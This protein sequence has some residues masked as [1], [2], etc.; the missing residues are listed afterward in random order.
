MI[1]LAPFLEWGRM[2]RDWTPTTC[3]LYAD[4]VRAAARWV[5]EHRGVSLTGAGAGDVADW[6]AQLSPHPGTRNQY[7]CALVAYYEWRIAAGLHDGPNPAETLPSHRQRRRVPIAVT[8]DVAGRVLAAADELDPQW[9]SMITVALHTGL[10]ATELRTLPWSAVTPGFVRVLGKGSHERVVPLHPRA[11]AA[12]ER[13]RPSAPTS[14]WVW[15]SPAD[16]SRP[17]SYAT[18][19]RRVRQAGDIAGVPGLRPHMLRHTAATA[20]L[21]SG[22]TLAEVRDVLGHQSVGTTSGYLRT[23][24]EQLSAAVGRVHY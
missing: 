11:T 10:R 9:G 18:L 4:R 2:V 8:S 3:D 12:L 19:R 21:E 15:P 24:P 16:P 7:R 20:M 13:W 6:Y 23:R 22:A 5:R 14:V 17:V 1:S